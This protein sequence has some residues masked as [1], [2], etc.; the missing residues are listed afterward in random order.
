MRATAMR[1]VRPCANGDTSIITLMRVPRMATMGL[2]GL[3]AASLLAPVRGITDITD[4]AIGVA[5]ITDAD[6]AMV[7]ASMDVA[8]GITIDS[9]ASGTQA[10]RMLAVGTAEHTLEAATAAGR[11]VAADFMAEAAVSTVAVEVAST[12][13]AVAGSTAEAADTDNSCSDLS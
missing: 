8:V 1:R 2:T 7:V 10:D 9:Q 12:V 4:T 3:R 5:A 11:M 6:G 13:E